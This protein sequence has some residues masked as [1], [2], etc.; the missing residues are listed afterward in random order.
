MDKMIKKL[1]AFTLAEACITLIIIG[2]IAAITIPSIKVDNP[3]HKGQK[4]QAEKMAGYL[5]QAANQM[6][7]NDAGL[8]DFKIL[9]LQDTVF[10]IEDADS[11]PKISKLFQSYLTNVKLNVPT[12]SD[13][14]GK[15]IRKYNGT[16]TEMVLKD[17]YTE[18][19]YANDG[20][21]L[22]VRT[23]GSCA[24]TEQF[25]NPP[26]YT[27]PYSVSNICGSI[28]FDVNG[29]GRPNKLGSDQY[30]IPID[31]RGVKYTEG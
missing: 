23:Y 30:I 5:V 21:L 15:K 10:S 1:N 19:F 6:L 14:F 13:Y 17:T 29:E 28:F 27:V 26:E 8:D 31:E 18:F 22:G 9:K 25:A 16:S 4:V 20:I 2:I 7:I 24:S 3:A 11:A 12:T